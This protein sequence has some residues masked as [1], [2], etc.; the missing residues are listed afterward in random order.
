MRFYNH[1][2]IE[3]NASVFEMWPFYEWFNIGL[4]WHET[5]CCRGVFVM[6]PITDGF[7]E[8]LHDC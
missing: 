4:K 2:E 6:W 3:F 7:M 5:R 1:G 8:A